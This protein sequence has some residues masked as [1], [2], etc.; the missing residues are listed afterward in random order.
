MCIDSGSCEC[1][2][3]H[4]TEPAAFVAKVSKVAT[5]AQIREIILDIH[6][7]M[8]H[9]NA[10]AMAHAI[11]GNCPTWRLPKSRKVT[12]KQVRKVLKEHT[13]LDCILA[14][15]NLAPPSD[16]KEEVSHLLP[17][18]LIAADPV[19]PI[20][21]PTRDGHQWFFVFKCMGTG[22]VHT[23]T[24]KTKDAF[25]SAFE[26]T[27]DYYKSMNR[28]PRILRTDSEILLQSNDM[29]QALIQAKMT[30]QMSAPYRHFQNSVER[31]ILT[32]VKG[33]S[34]LLHSQQWLQSNQWNL[35][36][37]HF[38]DLRNH[39]PNVHNKFKSPEHR[40]TGKGTS[41]TRMF[42]F[43]F[44]ELVAVGI[45][46][47]LRT[48][49]FDL[50]NDVGIYVGRPEGVVDACSI[51]FPE[52]G[53]ILTR[54][55]VYKLEVEDDTVLRYFQRRKD[56]REKTLTPS[57]FEKTLKE[58]FVDFDEVSLATGGDPIRIS[59]PLADEDI[60][61]PAQPHRSPLPPPSDRVLRSG[62]GDHIQSL[63][64]I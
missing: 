11:S 52:T 53:Q 17:G 3:C 1:H 12:A 26:Q 30:H 35:A 19:G 18:E 48:W 31:E 13:C 23:Y 39:T 64:R 38:G 24:A 36:V 41:I 50:R 29:S 45:P 42:Q 14:K 6:H 49:K 55:S 61:Y 7:R 59:L 21:P 25:Q 58:Y 40:V 32:I 9:P 10:E 43:G 62:G 28:T 2:D 15:R 20:W 51:Y 46:K 56:M 63:K 22:K 8:G 5:S 33:A 47:E 44:G 16:E 37:H 60:R 57:T 34:L 54:G 4:S 27:V